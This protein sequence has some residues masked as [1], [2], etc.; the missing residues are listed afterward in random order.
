MNDASAVAGAANSGEAGATNAGGKVRFQCAV[1]RDEAG[2][3]V[4]QKG[5][6]RPRRHM[7][8]ALSFSAM[9]EEQ[10]KEEELSRHRQQLLSQ[11]LGWVMLG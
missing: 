8:R 2:V 4:V 9:T 11:V 10:K 7:V 1:S 5:T 3:A 6:P